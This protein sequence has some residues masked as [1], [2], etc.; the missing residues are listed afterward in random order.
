MQ[1]INNNKSL[2]E[3]IALLENVQQSE[4]NLLVQHFKFTIHSLNPLNMIKEKFNETISSPNLKN[5]IIQETIGLA[6]GLLTNKLILGSSNNIVKKVLA[7]VV[8]TGI[9]RMSEIDPK[10]VKKNGITFLQNVLSKM[11]ING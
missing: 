10:S 8:Q 11:K 4:G 2:A 9:A 5:K 1:V 7:T 6:T 3:A